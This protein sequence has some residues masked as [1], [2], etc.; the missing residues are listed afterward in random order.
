LADELEE[1]PARTLAAM[2]IESGVVNVTNRAHFW[3]T[4][5]TGRHPN[6]AR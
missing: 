1:Q 4:W 6:T 3:K 2:K 5:L